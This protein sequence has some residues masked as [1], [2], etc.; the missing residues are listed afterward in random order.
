MGG[1]SPNCTRRHIADMVIGELWHVS[2]GGQP[3]KIGVRRCCPEK[4]TTRFKR[5]TRIRGSDAP[6]QDYCLA[7]WISQSVL[8]RAR[9][10]LQAVELRCECLVD[11]Q[12]VESMRVG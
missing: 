8:A 1:L 4:S 7:P 6:V 5:A 11:E 3:A 2:T 10:V 12:G 9:A